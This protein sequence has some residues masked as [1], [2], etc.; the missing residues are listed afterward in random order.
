[1]EAPPAG[2]RSAGGGYHTPG[3]G[4]VG[5]AVLRE[6]SVQGGAGGK[7]VTPA[8]SPALPLAG[9]PDVAVFTCPSLLCRSRS[10]GELL[11]S[12]G[13]SATTAGLPACFLPP[14]L[15]GF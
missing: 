6:C 2:T 12:T 8:A 1:M 13:D 7:G 5:G 14:K 15:R 10:A 11:R 3:G 9:L 4:R